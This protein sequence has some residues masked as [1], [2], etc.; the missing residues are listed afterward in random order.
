VS[1]TDPRPRRSIV[2]L[3][4][5]PSAIGIAVLLVVLRL[6]YQPPRVPTYTLEGPADAGVIRR[7]DLFEIALRPDR[8]LT[9][10]IAARGF[11]V[12]GDEVRPWDPPFEVSVQGTVRLSGTAASLFAGVPD[13]PWVVTLAVGR[14]EVLPTAPSDILR[15]QSSSDDAEG[16]RLLRLPIELERAQ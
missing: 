16:W 3:L 8:A 7:G 10:A 6:H 15:A 11:L 2:A 12:R 4:L 9:G 14:P 5:V 1:R 13:G